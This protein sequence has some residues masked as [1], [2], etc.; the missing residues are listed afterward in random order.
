MRL[1]KYIAHTGHCSRR[2]ADELI[3]AGAVM[4]NGIQVTSFHTL[5]K[6]DDAVTINGVDINISKTSVWLYNKPTK[7]ITSQKDPEG[8][9]T[10]FQ[11]IPHNLRNLISVG[12]LDYNTEGLLLMTNNGDLAKYI[13]DP[14]NNIPRKYK[15]RVFGR[16]NKSKIQRVRNGVTIDMMSYK[17]IKVVMGDTTKNNSWIEMTLTEGKNRE[18]R[19]IIEFLDLRVSRL[20]RAEYGIFKLGKLQTNNIVEATD[21]QIKYYLDQ[22]K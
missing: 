20:I 22:C 3:S 2:A 14:K 6:E 5:I 21:E 16:I 15:I 13:S 9:P 7:V 19:N 18:I 1:A 17:P 8:R 12:R 11:Q 10:V 4:I